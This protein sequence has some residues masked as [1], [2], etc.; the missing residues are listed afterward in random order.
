MLKR[1]KIAPLVTIVQG[2]GFA[3]GAVTIAGR[4]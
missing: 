2:N 4:G 3:L 1:K